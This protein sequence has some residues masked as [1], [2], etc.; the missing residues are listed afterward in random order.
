MPHEE[1]EREQFLSVAFRRKDLSA[2]GKD[3]NADLGACSRQGERCGRPGN[4]I[5]PMLQKKLRHLLLSL[6]RGVVGFYEK[7][8]KVKADVAA[9]LDSPRQ[10]R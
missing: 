4:R 8:I 5:I 9:V 2:A 7:V 6:T 10:H 3:Q 1:P